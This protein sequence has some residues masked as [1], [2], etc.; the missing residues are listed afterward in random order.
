MKRDELNRF[1]GRMCSLI[2]ENIE[3]DQDNY[4]MYFTGPNFFGIDFRAYCDFEKKT[5]LCALSKK[6]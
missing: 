3:P 5:I 1:I 6:L 2:D 4:K